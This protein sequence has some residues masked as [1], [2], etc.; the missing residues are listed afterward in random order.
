[1]MNTMKQILKE[2]AVAMFMTLCLITPIFLY[3]KGYI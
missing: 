1:M 2:L 3:F